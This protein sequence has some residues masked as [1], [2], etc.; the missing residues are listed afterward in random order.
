MKRI[1]DIA[2]EELGIEVEELDVEEID[3]SDLSY[4]RRFE[5]LSRDTRTVIHHLFHDNVDEA[6]YVAT[7][8]INSRARPAP[9][10]IELHRLATRQWR[11]PA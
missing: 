10:V 3:L 7:Q 11:Q 2:D 4:D 1:E 9:W 5:L 6:A 8:R